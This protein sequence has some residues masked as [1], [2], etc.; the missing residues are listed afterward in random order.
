MI[1]LAAS[2][3]FLPIKG[4]VED[5]NK[6]YTVSIYLDE[7]GKIQDYEFAEGTGDLDECNGRFCITPEF[8][9]GTY[10]YF[11]TEAWPVI[12]RAFRGTPVLLKER[13][14]GAHRR[15]AR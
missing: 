8:L 10:A 1:C 15:P 6:A 7:E 13:G 3:P 5:P 12:P 11:L 9:E 4:G 14:H 2:I